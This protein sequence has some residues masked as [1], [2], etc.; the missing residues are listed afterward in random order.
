MSYW[1][2]HSEWPRNAKMEQYLALIENRRATER[3]ESREP[4]NASSL[5]D[6]TSTSSDQDPCKQKSAPY[7]HAVFEIQMMRKNSHMGSS[8]AGINTASND[9]C[10]TLLNEPQ[11]LPKH[12]VFDDSR[13][14][15][16]CA[17]LVGENEAKVIRL[18]GPLIVPSA[19]A[20]ADQGAAHLEVVRETTNAVWKISRPF[21]DSPS[22]SFSGPL[23]RPY[24]GLGFQLRAFTSQQLET[25]DPM[26]RNLHPVSTLIA[27]THNMYFPFFSAEVECGAGDLVVADRQNAYTQSICLRGLHTLFSMVGREKELNGEINGFSISHNRE[28]VKIWGHYIGYVGDEVHYY[29]HPISSFCLTHQEGRDGWTA[30]TFVKNMYDHWVPKHFKRICDIIDSVTLREAAE[31]AELSKPW[32]RRRAGVGKEV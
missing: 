17:R 12:T 4:S 15:K 24:I 11:T 6:T 10:N 8:V 29:R 32:R 23:P 25:L 1:T 19:E 27:A 22:S 7:E 26:L 13:L 18:I 5:A 3:P 16:T 9:L 20:L 21:L 2:Q 31:Q 30:Y 14:L 28:M